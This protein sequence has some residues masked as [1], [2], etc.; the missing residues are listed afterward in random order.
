MESKRKRRD[1][2]QK[3]SHSSLWIVFWLFTFLWIT[4]YGIYS[5]NLAVLRNIR[6]ENARKEHESIIKKTLLEY[7]QIPVL[8]INGYELEKK[9]EEIQE[10]KDASFSANVFGNA[11][12]YLEYRVPIALLEGRGQLAIG[13]D[14]VVFPFMGEDPPKIIISKKVQDTGF[15]L[16]ISEVS[17]LFDAINLAKKLQVNLPKLDGTV[18]LDESWRLC[19]IVEKVKVIFGDTKSLDKNVEIFGKSL[20]NEQDLLSKITE[21]NL[22]EPSHPVIKRR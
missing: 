4:S 19:L 1:K 14:G 10:V 5:G 11:V 18:D 7:Q 8:Q 3:K 12:L 15:I 2:F 6:V 9:I 20:A 17:A 22:V 16:C 13:E 21:M